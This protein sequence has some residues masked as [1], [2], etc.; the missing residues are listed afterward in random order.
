MGCWP[1]MAGQGRGLGSG[2]AALA[3]TLEKLWFRSSFARGLSQPNP[4]PLIY[5]RGIP[6]SQDFMQFCV[7]F[8]YPFWRTSGNPR[9]MQFRH[10]FAQ[11]RWFPLRCRPGVVVFRDG[12]N[13]E[14]LMWGPH[15]R[16]PRV[17]WG[18]LVGPGPAACS[19]PIRGPFWPFRGPFFRDFDPFLPVFS[20][21]RSCSPC[22]WYER[23]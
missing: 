18:C 1:A 9:D 13:I 6:P 14:L 23:A 15:G 4:P 11:K 17:P 21:F 16:V 8:V 10:V 19:W 3:G 2:G 12:P 22:P 20:S 7:W 5:L